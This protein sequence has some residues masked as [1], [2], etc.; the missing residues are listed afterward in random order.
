[1]ALLNANKGVI[2]IE[3]EALPHL[4]FSKN[5]IPTYEVIEQL[6]GLLI[7]NRNTVIIVGSEKK[8][9]LMEWFGN[10]ASGNGNHF[11]LVAESG[12]L[13]KPGNKDWKTLTGLDDMS[14]MSQVKNVMEA[15]A[16]NIDGSFVVE[17]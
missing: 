9:K 13:Y 8:E 12:Y 3:I 6:R 10:G 15:Y 7:D 17:R 5:S 1:M 16:D 11:W 14:W 4:K 2:I